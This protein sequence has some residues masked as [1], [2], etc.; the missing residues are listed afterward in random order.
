MNINSWLLLFIQF[1]KNEIYLQVLKITIVFCTRWNTMKILYNDIYCDECLGRHTIGDY[2]FI[3]EDWW[4]AEYGSTVHVETNGNCEQ[5]LKILYELFDVGTHLIR[6][7]EPGSFLIGKTDI[8]LE[9][10]ASGNQYYC[11][12]CIKSQAKPNARSDMIYSG[13]FLPVAYI[14]NNGDC[15]KCLKKMHK[16]FDPSQNVISRIKS[17]LFLIKSEYYFERYQV[18]NI[19]CSYKNSEIIINLYKSEFLNGKE[20]Q[21]IIDMDMFLNSLSIDTILI[22]KNCHNGVTGNAAHDEK[23]KNH[24]EYI[25]CRLVNID[26]YDDIGFIRNNM[27]RI[28]STQPHRNVKRAI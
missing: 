27:Y 4:K 28:E 11:G 3:K 12:K 17:N 9:S 13:L 20:E 26:N 7:I 23:L 21:E 8:V 14:Q 22:F 16:V 24:L 6:Q 1:Y 10:L 2:S 15:E 19:D 18:F 25:S 5:C